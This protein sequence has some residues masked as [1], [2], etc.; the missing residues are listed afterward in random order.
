MRINT[1][2]EEPLKAKSKPHIIKATPKTSTNI[3][4]SILFMIHTSFTFVINDHVDLCY[5][6]KTKEHQQPL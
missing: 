3:P 1:F 5:Q 4:H 2:S 6:D